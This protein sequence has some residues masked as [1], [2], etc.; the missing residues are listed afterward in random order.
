MVVSSRESLIK[1]LIETLY[2]NRSVIGNFRVSNLVLET[3]LLI[4]ELPIG[5][6]FNR[7]ETRV[8]VNFIVDLIIFDLMAVDENSSNGKQLNELINS[9]CHPADVR[10][11]NPI[12]VGWSSRAQIQKSLERY[13]ITQIR[14]KGL[15][16]FSASTCVLVD[17][18]IESLQW[19]WKWESWMTN[20][21]NCLMDLLIAYKAWVNYTFW[22]WIHLQFKSWQWCVAVAAVCN[23]GIRQWIA[24]G[25][26]N[27]L[28]D[29]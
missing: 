17:G 9:A 11:K 1:I 13:K 18:H 24:V 23:G 20:N 28:A 7:I 21:Q 14:V 22:T 19:R 2:G 4:D 25:A 16:E 29:L 27:A 10:S 12:S 3:H 5:N 8:E 15:E 26:P 6:P